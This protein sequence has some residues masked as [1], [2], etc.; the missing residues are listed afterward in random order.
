M[1]L[2]IPVVMNSLIC[3]LLIPIVACFAR[4][5]SSNNTVSQKNGVSLSLH[6]TVVFLLHSCD[7]L[8]KSLLAGEKFGDFSIRGYGD[9]LTELSQRSWVEKVYDLAI[10]K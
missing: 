1:L 10:V 2:L 9:F 7:L 4:S 5:F 6:L 8:V 3:V